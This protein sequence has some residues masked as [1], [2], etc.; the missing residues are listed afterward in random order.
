MEGGGGGGGDEELGPGERPVVA[1]AVVWMVNPFSRRD[2]EQRPPF[3]RIFEKF[4]K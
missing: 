4:T 1:K 3:A 2:G